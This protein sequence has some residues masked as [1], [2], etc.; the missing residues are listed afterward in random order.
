MTVESPPQDSS[1]Y[2][3]EQP[4]NLSTAVLYIFTGSDWCAVCKRFEKNVLSDSLFTKNME[5]NNIEIQIIDFP[6]R[7]KLTKEVIKHNESIAETYNFQGVFPTLILSK[8]QEKYES[9]K[10]KNEKGDEFSELVIEKLK[11]LN[12]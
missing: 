10:Y 7:K 11:D 5:L 8:T 12:E 2:T 1:V 4:S 3:F 6:Q 9:L